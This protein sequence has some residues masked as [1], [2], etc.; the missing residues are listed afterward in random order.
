MRFVL[1]L[2]SPEGGWKD[3]TPEDMRED[4]KHWSAYG[5]ETVE[6]GVFIAGEGLQP[7]A[8]AKTVRGG[9]GEQPVVSDGPFAET[10]E[11]VGGFYLLE[12]ESIDEAVEWAKKVPLREGAVE[13]R[14]AMDYSEYGYDDPADAGATPAS[15]ASS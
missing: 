8:E 5:A 9:R 1:M 15:N 12:C 7:S 13:V 14:P 6:K 3:V 11:Q 2:I 4:M 10:K